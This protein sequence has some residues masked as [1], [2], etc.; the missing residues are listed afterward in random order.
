MNQTLYNY[1]VIERQLRALRLTVEED[2][3]QTYSALGLSGDS[4]YNDYDNGNSDY[5]DENGNSDYDN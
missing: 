3:G 5:D 1:Y 2:L 4:G